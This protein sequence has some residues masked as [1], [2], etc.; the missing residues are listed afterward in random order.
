MAYAGP[1]SPF[2][3]TVKT[4]P[5]RVGPDVT[6]QTSFF[7]AP[8]NKSIFFLRS[9]QGNDDGAAAS[10]VDRFLKR[11]EEACAKEVF[12]RYADPN[13]H[14][15]LTDGL[16][17]AL[18]EMGVQIKSEEVQAVMVMTD[19]EKNGGL[20]FE[21]FRRALMKPPTKL[22]QWVGTLPLARAVYICSSW[23]VKL[24][25]AFSFKN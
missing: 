8:H 9:Q 21:E 25:F 17:R 10:S 3:C 5:P 20:D 24:F 18:E 14:L 6:R 4:A 19:V 2:R 13:A 11:R 12:E 1:V 15:I 7:L 23:A 22:E 16:Q